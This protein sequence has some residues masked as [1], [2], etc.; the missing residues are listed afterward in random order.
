MS[1]IT[2]FQ[3]LNSWL[4]VV[5]RHI[6]GEHRPEIV[7]HRLQTYQPVLIVEH[8]R[9]LVIKRRTVVVLIRSGR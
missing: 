9:L 3:S 8:R 7:E 1:L 6:A 2:D 5:K 4:A